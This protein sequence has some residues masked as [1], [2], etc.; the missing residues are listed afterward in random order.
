MAN[1][2]QAKGVPPSVVPSKNEAVTAFQA[3][4]G[5]LTL[6]STYGEDPL[7]ADPQKYL[8]RTQAFESRYP[9]LSRIFS[10]LVNGE[11]SL[12]RSALLF[13]IDITTRMAR[14]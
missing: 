14:V 1:N 8:M 3:A 9:D 13:Y 4:G 12:F 11:E 6:F 7:A 10:D 5:H 2:Y